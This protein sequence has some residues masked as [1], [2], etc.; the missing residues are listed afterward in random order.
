MFWLE[1]AL[2]ICP[3]SSGHDIQVSYRTG[4][5]L[6]RSTREYA[7]Q[8]KK[9]VTVSLIFLY[10]LSAEETGFRVPTGNYQ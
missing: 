9:G 6:A 1:L 7:F 4:N 8:S 2:L 5:S 3:T 10:L